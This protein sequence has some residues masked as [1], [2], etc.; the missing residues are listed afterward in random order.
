MPKKKKSKSVDVFDFIEYHAKKA[1]P[2]SKTPVCDLICSYA[3]D[4]D[5]EE[6]VI[7]LDIAKQLEYNS[8]YYKKPKH[9]PSNKTKIMVSK[10]RSRPFAIDVA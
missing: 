4:C 7:R 5:P 3:G 2:K 9:V 6:L 8:T 1:Y 10:N